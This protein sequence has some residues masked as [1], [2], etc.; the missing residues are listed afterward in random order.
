MAAQ[1]SDVAVL[2]NMAAYHGVIATRI[3]GV[4]TP[5]SANSYLWRKKN[6]SINGVAYRGVAIIIGDNM[7]LVHR[8]NNENKAKAAISVVK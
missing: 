3:C 4:S 2:D 8:E 6:I 1:R 5:Q 7:A